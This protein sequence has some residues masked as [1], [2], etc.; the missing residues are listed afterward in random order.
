[1]HLK[2]P[3]VCSSQAVLRKKSDGLKE[4]TSE[5]VVEVPG[6]QLLLTRMRKAIEDILSKERGNNLEGG[7]HAELVLHTTEGGVHVWIIAAKP[8]AE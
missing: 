1:M 6:R 2:K 7:G 3:L 8:V 5:V 4:S